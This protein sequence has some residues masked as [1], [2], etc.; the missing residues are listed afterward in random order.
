[1]SHMKVKAEI[2]KIHRKKENRALPQFFLVDTVMVD[3]DS[4]HWV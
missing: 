3:T 4:L 1:M 2:K